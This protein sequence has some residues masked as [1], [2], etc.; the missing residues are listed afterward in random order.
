MILANFAGTTVLRSI[1]GV[2][3]EARLATNDPTASGAKYASPLQ[4]E[5]ASA[6]RNLR[7]RNASFPAPGR[8]KPCSLVPRLSASVSTTETHCRSRGGSTSRSSARPWSSCSWGKPHPCSIG[9]TDSTGKSPPLIERRDA[10]DVPRRRTVAIASR[11][12]TH[13]SSVNGNAQ[14]GRYATTGA[15][16]TTSDH[17]GDPR[18]SGHVGAHSCGRCRV[19]VNCPSLSRR[20]AGASTGVHNG[21]SSPS[22]SI[23]S[24]GGFV[25]RPWWGSTD[26]PNGGTFT[27]SGCQ[28]C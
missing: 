26:R 3:L 12:E 2:V 19:R 24:C 25:G 22:S 9:P 7:A 4:G 28:P 17:L 1:A 5:R 15:A 21:R 16:R 10:R 13:P 23:S 11:H 8:L 27:C 20:N 18:C 6:H 14:A